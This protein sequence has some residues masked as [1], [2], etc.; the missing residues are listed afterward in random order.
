MQRRK[1]DP[2]TIGGGAAPASSSSSLPLHS[3]SRT[4]TSSSTA[5][6][7]SRKSNRG[8]IGGIGGGNSS[9]NN[10]KKGPVQVFLRV[11]ILLIILMVTFTF[12]TILSHTHAETQDLKVVRGGGRGSFQGS[13]EADAEASISDYSSVVEPDS[14]IQEVSSS[15]ASQHVQ[16]K[17]TS[18]EATAAMERQPSHNVD[19]EISLKA[20]LSPLYQLQQQGQELGSKIVTRWLG[21]SDLDYWFAK[22]KEETESHE[23]RTWED[24]IKEEREEMKVKDVALNPSL[25]NLADA[26]VDMHE[27]EHNDKSDV[28]T[29]DHDAGDADADA[30]EGD[31]VVVVVNDTQK[32]EIIT[33]TNPAPPNTH[34]SLKPTFGKHR[35]HSDAIFAFAEGYELKIYLTF[36]ESLKATGYNGDLVLSVS[37]LDKLKPGVEEYLRSHH[38]EENE[39]GLNVVVYTVTWICYTGDG[40]Q[41]E[42]ANEGQRM[43]ELV[44]M[45]STEDGED[46]KD[47]REPRPVATAR[48]E[49]Y[50][51]WSL[52]Y[53]PNNWFMLIDSR[54]AFFQTDPFVSLER[55]KGDALKDGLLYFFGVSL[56]D[57]D[58]A[59]YSCCFY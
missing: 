59:Y 18:A 51:A 32:S 5:P 28:D 15:S 37:A 3:T 48:Y 11:I 8:T 30:G 12:V 34:V 9:S 52:Q 17:R 14:G 35:S 44:G 36:L 41:A 39:V 49:L 1:V 45:Y 40:K 13:N 6:R 54:D 50:W 23:F 46:V 20:H 57:S 24:T 58:F 53:D 43:C 33:F 4:S 2:S 7:S 38:K 29:R 16:R 56:Y 25:Y 22:S 21:R 31:N 19:G 26:V 55:V 27:E 42:G 10:K 47:P